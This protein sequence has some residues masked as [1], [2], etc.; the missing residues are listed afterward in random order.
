MQLPQAHPEPAEAF[1][2][3]QGLSDVS[4]QLSGLLVDAS[5]PGGL[6]EEDTGF[7]ELPAVTAAPRLPAATPE[8]QE[9]PADHG[10]VVAEGPEDPGEL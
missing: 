10:L 9:A 2:F 6:L 4:T 5:P 8:G 3:P 1:P 7:V